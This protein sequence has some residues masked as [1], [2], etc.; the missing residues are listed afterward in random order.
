MA[1]Q[2]RDVA[3]SFGLLLVPFLNATLVY[4]ELLVNKI[5]LFSIGVT[6]ASCLAYALIGLGVAT[7]VFQN[8]KVLFRQ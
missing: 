8:E 4:K 3:P 2:F 7:R 5:D 6:I 1:V